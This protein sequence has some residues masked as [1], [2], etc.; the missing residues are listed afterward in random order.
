MFKKMASSCAEVYVDSNE[1]KYAPTY[2]AYL[3]HDDD[4]TYGT[5]KSKTTFQ[6]TPTGPRAVCL[7]YLGRNMNVSSAQQLQHLAKPVATGEIGQTVQN[8]Y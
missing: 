2:G 3:L 6:N 4:E 8:L 1:P 5:V 7:H